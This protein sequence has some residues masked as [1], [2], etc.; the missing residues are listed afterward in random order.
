MF[1]CRKS[2]FKKDA[3]H[4]EL[5]LTW[6]TKP[7]RTAAANN[8]NRQGIV[9]QWYAI[10]CLWRS[11]GADGGGIEVSLEPRRIIVSEIGPQD[12]LNHD[13]ACRPG[14]FS[15]VLIWRSLSIG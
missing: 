5:Q 6:A 10:K 15:T 11:A 2:I 12:L 13:D 9:R 4:A 3:P 7:E 14:G 1:C 8:Q